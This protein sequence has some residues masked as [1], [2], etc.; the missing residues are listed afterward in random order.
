MAVG[1][2]AVTTAILLVYAHVPEPQVQIQRTYIT[3]APTVTPTFQTASP[4]RTPSTATPFQQM[5]SS[6]DQQTP[7]SPRFVPRPV[8]LPVPTPVYIPTPVPVFTHTAGLGRLQHGPLIPSH[9]S[10]FDPTDPPAGQQIL[11]RPDTARP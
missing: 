10:Q 11:I 7:Y 6:L 9:N 8:E 1:G 2:L 4:L 5:L 3:E